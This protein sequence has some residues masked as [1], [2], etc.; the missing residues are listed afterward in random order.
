MV[1]TNRKD[2]EMIPKIIHYIWLG[3]GEIPANL[4]RYM[5]SWEILKKA[6][7]EIVRWDENNL[8]IDTAPESIKQAMLLKKYAFVADYFRLKVLYE[9]GG[10]YF[11][12]DIEVCRNFEELLNTG[13]LL[14][15][16]FDAS[17]GTA[18]IG[19]EKEN[20]L[21]RDLMNLYETAEYEM[22]VDKNEYVL[23][24]AMFSEK[25]LTNNNDLFTAYF[26]KKIDGFRLNGKEQHLSDVSIYPKE[27]FEG[28]TFDKKHNFTIHHCLGSWRRNSKESLWKY[29]IK[30]I[31]EKIPIIWTIR[32]MRFRRKKNMSL[33]F[34]DVYLNEINK[35]M[36]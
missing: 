29:K 2:N 25:K 33:P 5:S 23:K 11:D 12:T 32:D 27:Y 30:T 20:H 8:P 19:A 36:K 22:N 24:F 9:Q 10:I 3:G 14:G 34:S 31:G 15:F 28:Y 4:R 16:I 6:G 17:I 13:V 35:S 7:Y 26:L 21:I 18:V 1:E